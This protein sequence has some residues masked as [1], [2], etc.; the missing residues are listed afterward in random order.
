MFSDIVEDIVYEDRAKLVTYLLHKC[1]EADYFG[2][3]IETEDVRTWLKEYN[4]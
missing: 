4:A 1:D 3:D 2:D